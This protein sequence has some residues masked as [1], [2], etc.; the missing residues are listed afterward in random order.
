[1]YKTG[2][3]F[4]PD[5]TLPW[6]ETGVKRLALERNQLQPW[7]DLD[8]IDFLWQ[9]ERGAWICEG[10]VDGVLDQIAE[11]TEEVK[12]NDTSN[13]DMTRE[14]ANQVYI[15]AAVPKRNGHMS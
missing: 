2:G 4:T 5:Q 14:M 10:G 9:N 15:D 7:A 6:C 8:I 1:M 13:A 11:A 3:D 12:E